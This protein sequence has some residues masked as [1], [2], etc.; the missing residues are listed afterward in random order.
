MMDTNCQTNL[1]TL[2]IHLETW[3]KFTLTGCTSAITI[4]TFLSNV[5]V[6]LIIFRTKQQKNI[7]CRFVLLLSLSDFLLACHTQTV[8]FFAIFRSKIS[9]TFQIIAQFWSV[10]LIILP[11][12]IIMA[13]AF[14]TM[15]KLNALPLSYC[16][17]S[18]KRVHHIC[19]LC[20]AMAFVAAVLYTIFTVYGMFNSFHFIMM[21]VMLICVITGFITYIVLYTRLYC[22]V[23]ET[24]T[25][26]NKDDKQ[27]DMSSAQFRPVY[28][29]ST[30]KVIKR[31]LTAISIAYIPFIAVSLY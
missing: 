9:C 22:H 12:N 15:V 31:K 26:R 10:F 24:V 18:I 25:L 6:I 2:A 23:K 28:L 30:A 5:T 11:G 4:L 8:R 13:M 1:W 19:L 7:F 3:Q 29:Y 27:T 21:I 14:H 16:N 17:T 20:V